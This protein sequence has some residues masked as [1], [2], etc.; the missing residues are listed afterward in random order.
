VNCAAKLFEPCSATITTLKDDKLHWN[1]IASRLPGFD[2]EGAKE[3]YPIPFDPDHSLSARAMLE[4]RIIEIPDIAA[5]DTPELTRKAAAAGSFRSCT[6]VPLIHQNTSIGTIILVHPQ[7]GF[8]LSEKQ[9]ALVQTFADQAVIA[10]QNARLFDV[11]Q[12][13][14][15]DLEEALRYQTGSASILNVIASSPTDVQPVLKAIVESACELCGAYDAVALLKE[16][17]HLMFG[18]HHGPIPVDKSRLRI[19]R[20]LTTGLAMIEQRPVHVRDLLSPEGD[21]FPEAQRRARQ[22]GYRTV[23]SVL[24]LRDESVGVIGIRRCEANP[25]TE[26]QIELVSTFADQAVIA[27]ENVRLFE[28]VQTRTRDLQESLQ[29]QTATSD[30]LKIISRSSVDLETVLDT[31]VETVARL[32]RADQT[33]MLRRR[34]NMYHLDAAYGLSAE[35]EK[36]QRSHP[37][38][39][40]R[41]TL[42]GRVAL[43]RRVV[44]TRR[45]LHRQRD[46]ASDYLRRP[47]GDRDRE[48]S[49]VRRIARSPGR[50][51]RDLRQHG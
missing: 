40:D 17:D 12:A 19:N 32:C 27:I 22:F 39:P 31:L 42:S 4:R 30:V 26:K 1:A 9:L 8:E 47:G 38:A 20:N 41:G 49:A 37:F 7:A 35:A 44:H 18:A 14:T 28:E 2:P 50:A 45:P 6:F 48:C 15:D 11:V 10:I 25:F 29:Q 16:G 33:A 5:P 3:I 24:L 34:D 21:Q 36:F 51:A 23:L 46:R 43:E 13:R